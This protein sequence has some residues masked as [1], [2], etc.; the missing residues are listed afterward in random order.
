MLAQADFERFGLFD[1]ALPRDQDDDHN[2]RIIRGGGRVWRIPSIVR[3]Y[4]PRGT[5]CVLFRQYSQ[6]GFWKVQVIR[7]HK[8][9][10]SIRHLVP[11]AFV[12][13]NILL[14]LISDI[15]HTTALVPLALHLPSARPS[16]TVWL[17]LLKAYAVALLGASAAAAATAGWALLPVLPWVF[18]PY[19]IAY[20]WGFLCGLIHYCRLYPS[21]NLPFS[22][23]SR[24]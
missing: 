17:L 21:D 22:R 2:L 20:G 10:A 11:G 5:L 6:Y 14:A 9:P 1:E 12:A 24:S 13:A 3:W 18:A 15:L 19:H 7:K 8:L 16:L 23:L 4:R